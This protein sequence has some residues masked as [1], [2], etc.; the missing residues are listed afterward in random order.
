MYT[1]ERM[2]AGASAQPQRGGRELEFNT[3]YVNSLNTD[4]KKKFQFQKN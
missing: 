2:R 3:L 1:P 4:A